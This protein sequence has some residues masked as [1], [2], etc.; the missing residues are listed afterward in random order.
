MPSKLAQA[1]AQQ[2][3]PMAAPS[4]TTLFDAGVACQALPLVL[5]GSVKVSKRADNGREIRLYGVQPGELCIVTVGCLL[6]GS[7]YSATGTT[8]TALRALALPRTLFMQLVAEHPPFREWVFKLFNE[9]V[10]GLMQLVEEVAFRKLDQR[11]A[12]WLLAHAPRVETSHQSIADE[13]GSVREIVSRLLRQFEEQGAVELGRER[14]E[15]R[16]PELLASWVNQEARPAQKS[17]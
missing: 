3:Q 1:V 11:L 15:I 2:L 4:G 17:G 12:A 7:A 8:E 6:G 16:A 10:T 9:R 14:I 5:E 13:L